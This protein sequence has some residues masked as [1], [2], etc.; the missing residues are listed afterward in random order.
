[1][2]RC[3]VAGF[4]CMLCVFCHVILLAVNERCGQRVPLSGRQVFNFDPEVTGVTGHAQC[5]K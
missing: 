2:S 3:T 1:M 4:N 5:G